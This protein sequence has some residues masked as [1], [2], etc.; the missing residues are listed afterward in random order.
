MYR[1]NSSLFIYC[2]FYFGFLYIPVLLLPIFSFNDSFHMVFPLKGF[3]F[4]WYIEMWN[5][6]RLHQA[7]W[8][9]IKVGVIASVISTFIALFAAKAFTRYKVKF[10]GLS[11][12]AILLPFIIPEI[13]IAVAFIVI[14][15]SMGLKLGLIPITI[16]HVLYLS[17][18]HI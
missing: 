14:W 1:K 2:I 3:T 18:I 15:T 9:S 4:D 17:L 8:N 12:G 7:L 5:K 6:A 10:S 11:Y 16:S 13:I